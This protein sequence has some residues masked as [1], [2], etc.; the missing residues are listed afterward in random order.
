MDNLGDSFFNMMV[1]MTTSNYPDVML[2][3]YQQNRQYFLFF[4]SYMLLG[5]FIILN[6]VLAI[7]YSNFKSYFE[8]QIEDKEEI[9][10][11]YFGDQFRLISQGQ[12]HL[13]EVQMFKMF[14]L[15]HSLAMNNN[16][17]K[18]TSDEEANVISE[19]QLADDDTLRGTQMLLGNSNKEFKKDITPR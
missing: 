10:L 9:R 4:G 17:D 12:D 19:L 13:D 6:L 5:M 15:I 7:I 16:S 1:L 18:L 11:Q 8:Q 14:L 3:A 2:P